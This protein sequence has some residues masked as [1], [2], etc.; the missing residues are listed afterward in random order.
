[1]ARLWGA[2]RIRRRFNF[3]GEIITE[4]RKV[5]WPSRAE[6]LRSTLMVLAVC[7]VL[8]ILLGVA[9]FGFSELVGRVFLTGR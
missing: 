1:M 6:L 7:I 9:D 8:A 3:F 5:L 2:R 4:L